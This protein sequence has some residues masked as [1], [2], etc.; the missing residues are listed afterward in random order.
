MRTSVSLSDELA[1]YV[2]EVASSADEND[3]EAIRE[4]LRHGRTQDARVADL[5]AETDRLQ[6]RVAEL[7]TELDRVKNEKRLLLE[8]REEKAELVRYVKQE[9]TAEQR[10]REAGFGTRLKWRLLGMPADD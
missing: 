6:E 9:R 10:W 4:A 7:E 3:A 8:E 5:A 1:S 2:A